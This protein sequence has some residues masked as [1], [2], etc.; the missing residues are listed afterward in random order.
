MFV[1]PVVADAMKRAGEE[2]PATGIIAMSSGTPIACAADKSA[3]DRAKSM[4]VAL[5]K[6]KVGNITTVNNMLV[7]RTGE[8][9]FVV[10]QS[11]S[12]GQT[13]QPLDDAAYYLSK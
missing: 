6:I 13:G 3:L 1:N 10:G 4:A 7:W 11:I 2:V 12:I 8:N 9:S 5:K